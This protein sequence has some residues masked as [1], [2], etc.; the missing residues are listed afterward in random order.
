MNGRVAREIRREARSICDPTKGLQRVNG[1]TLR[2][3]T[4]S[5]RGVIR[6]LKKWRNYSRRLGPL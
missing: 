4:T 1:E 5:Y 6:A 2:W 3:E